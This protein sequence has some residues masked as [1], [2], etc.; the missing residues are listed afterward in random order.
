MKVCKESEEIFRLKNCFC[1]VKLEFTGKHD[2]Y[3][4]DRCSDCGKEIKV[5]KSLVFCLKCAGKKDV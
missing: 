4:N 5:E 3:Y 2:D 1:G